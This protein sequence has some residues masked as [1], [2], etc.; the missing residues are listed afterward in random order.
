MTVSGTVCRERCSPEPSTIFRTIRQSKD[1]NSTSR[2]LVF[3]DC[4]FPDHGKRFHSLPWLQFGAVPFTL[5]V[6]PCLNAIL[7]QSDRG[8]CS[9]RFQVYV[10]LLST[11]PTS[12]STPDL[13]KSSA[14]VMKRVRPPA[15]SVSLQKDSKHKKLVFWL[16]SKVWVRLLRVIPALWTGCSSLCGSYTLT[17]TSLKLWFYTRVWHVL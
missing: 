10:V 13:L 15:A 1:S 17:S 14:E 16:S 5:Q 8:Q 3:S 6:I 4:D 12:P 11:P 2:H 7:I 9:W